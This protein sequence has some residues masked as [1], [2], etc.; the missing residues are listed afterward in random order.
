[1]IRR[2]LVILFVATAFLTVATGRRD[3]R[4]LRQRRAACGQ[5][6]RGDLSDDGRLACLSQACRDAVYG[7]EALEEGEFC[8]VRTRKFETCLRRTGVRRGV[9][10]Q[11]GGGK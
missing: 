8:F 2:H 6:H 5:R 4:A 3:D 7:D 10:R 11:R 9:A 1:M